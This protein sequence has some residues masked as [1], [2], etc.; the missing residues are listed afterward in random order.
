VWRCRSR[1]AA[2]CAALVL[3]AIAADAAGAR[4][5]PVDYSAR[6]VHRIN[7]F[8]ESHGLPPLRLSPRLERAARAH[9]ADMAAHRVLTHRSSSGATLLERL[10]RAGYRGRSV[11]ETLAAG[12][13]S[14]R[15]TLRLWRRS[16]LHRRLLLRRRFRSAGVGMARGR[17]GGAR[18]VYV[19]VDLGSR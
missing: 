7:G 3:T 13:L 18:G 4:L 11:G 6:L 10:R 1:L 15:L 17:V 9:S 5:S 19:S 16:R 12:R 14:P 2:A 8:R